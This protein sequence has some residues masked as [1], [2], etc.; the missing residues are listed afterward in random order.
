[1]EALK[2]PAA[3]GMIRVSEQE[4]NHYKQLEIQAKKDRLIRNAP[5]SL[6]V[7]SDN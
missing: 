4:I 5:I 6:K 7:R 3:A 2:Q 1:M